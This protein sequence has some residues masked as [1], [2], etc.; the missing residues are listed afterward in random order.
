MEIAAGMF[1]FEIPF[2]HA[3]DPEQSSA[4]SFHGLLE[5]RLPFARHTLRQ[6]VIPVLEGE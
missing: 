2:E 4:R 1:Q 5:I 6:V 3:V